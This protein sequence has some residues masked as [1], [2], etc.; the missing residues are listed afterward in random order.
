MGK[1]RAFFDVF[2]TYRT[3]DPEITEM[4]GSA[5]IDG[6]ECSEDQSSSRNWGYSVKYRRRI[7][8]RCLICDMMLLSIDNN[9]MK[10]GMTM[11]DLKDISLKMDYH[12][13]VA[14]SPYFKLQGKGE[15]DN[16]SEGSY[17]VDILDPELGIYV[18]TD[19]TFTNLS[20]NKELDILETRIASLLKSEIT[21]LQMLQKTV[22][23]ALKRFLNISYDYAP[24]PDFVV[25]TVG[26]I[27]YH[28]YQKIKSSGWLS[29]H[30]KYNYEIRM[31]G[32]DGIEY[33]VK[34]DE[35][36]DPSGKKLGEVSI[37]GLIRGK[38]Q[39]DDELYY[40][41]YHRVHADVANF[42]DYLE[43]IGNIPEFF[44]RYNTERW[45][46]EEAVKR[47]R[48]L[49]VSEK[50]IKDFEKYGIIPMVTHNGDGSISHSDYEKYERKWFKQDWRFESREVLKC[51][52]GGLPYLR[53]RSY[54][55]IPMD[56]YLYVEYLEE[57][58]ELYS[59]EL[60]EGE[61]T[62]L[63]SAIVFSGYDYEFGSIELELTKDG[64]IRVG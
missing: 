29:E 58:R 33:T 10:G 3:E 26:F 18:R 32:E 28:S 42:R 13:E 27:Y 14:G 6:I 24:D 12:F 48:F 56:A 20:A 47:L 4:P 35:I 5:R 39:K 62:L 37:C 54:G 50:E 16:Y 22:Y 44:E 25:G 43:A 52:R 19:C 23:I 2:P 7:S 34:E 8:C 36:L 46:I 38:T 1:E 60:K 9:Y 51:L 45:Q 55:A 64:P 53:F 21:P 40:D 49:G 61:K 31:K 63:M 41:E 57:E 15:V 30:M 17:D 59:N 11:K